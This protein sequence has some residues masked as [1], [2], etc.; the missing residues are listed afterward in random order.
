[1]FIL[2]N[3]ISKEERVFEEYKPAFFG[4]NEANLRRKTIEHEVYIVNYT[5]LTS[6]LINNPDIRLRRYVVYVRNDVIYKI[7][8]LT[9]GL[10]YK[11]FM[12]LRQHNN[13]YTFLMSDT[14]FG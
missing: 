11:Y 3:K 9:V 5:I 12:L 13:I 4:L 10:I 8:K 14:M 7:R 1:M 6:D 2:K